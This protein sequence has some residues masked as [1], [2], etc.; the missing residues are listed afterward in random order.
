MYTVSQD[1]MVKLTHNP[2][3]K[4]ESFSMTDNRS[5][6]NTNSTLSSTGMKVDNSDRTLSI[7]L[8]VLLIALGGMVLYNAYKKSKSKSSLGFGFAL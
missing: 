4:V 1:K 5:K 2:F 7:I 8:G 6:K 3:Q